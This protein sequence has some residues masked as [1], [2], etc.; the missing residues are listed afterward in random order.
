MNSPL[1]V[2]RDSLG[3]YARH[4][5]FSPRDRAKS[6]IKFD[7]LQYTFLQNSEP[8]GY[9][10]VLKMI[11]GETPVPSGSKLLFYFIDTTTVSIAN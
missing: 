4:V 11:H 8:Y 9:G 6:D 1:L 7:N 2:G 3:L 5:L 10:T